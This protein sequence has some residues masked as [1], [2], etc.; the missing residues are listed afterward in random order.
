MEPGVSGVQWAANSARKGELLE[1]FFQSFLVLGAIGI[2]FGVGFL[3]VARAE[4]AGA[5]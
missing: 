1:E 2:N 4:V 5:P 3:Q